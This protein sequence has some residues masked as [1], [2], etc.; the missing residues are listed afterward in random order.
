V[1]NPILFGKYHLIEKISAGG[2]AEVY[3]AKSYGVAGFE[4][5]LV[6]KKILPHLTSDEDFVRM[7]LDEARITVS[8]SHGNIVQVIELA[9]EGETYFM[10]MEY[11]HGYDL[12]RSLV[13]S[14]QSEP[15]P[16]PL[17]LYVLCEVL[18]ALDYA[19]RRKDREQRDLNIVHCD[20]SPQNVLLSFEG[21]VKL[22]DFGISRAAFQSASSQGVVRGKYAYMSPE[23]VEGRALDRRSDIFSVGIILWEMLTG[24]RLFKTDNVE[25]TLRKVL[26]APIPRPSELVPD[27][28]EELDRI[29]LKALSRNLK[30][31]YQEDQEM[32]EDLSAFMFAQ[33]MHVT[34]ADLAEYLRRIFAEELQRSR[35]DELGFGRQLRD[36]DGAGGSGRRSTLFIP[37]GS[38]RTIPSYQPPTDLAQAV[39]LSRIGA[40]VVC[41]EWN[42]R[43]GGGE[44]GTDRGKQLREV[45]DR[46]ERRVERLGGELWEVNH[47]S[48]VA[49]WRTGEDPA[50]AVGLAMN[51]ASGLHE[52]FRSAAGKDARAWV[53]DV[54]CHVGSVLVERR[55]GNPLF[56]WQITETFAIPRLLVNLGNGKGRVLVTR[57]ARTLAADHFSFKSVRLG[58]GAPPRLNRVQE[59]IP[60]EPA[61]GV[62]GVKYALY[63]RYLVRESMLATL[64]DRLRD[65]EEGKPSVVLLLGDEGMGKSRLREEYRQSCRKLG[66]AF[67]AGS[68]FEGTRHFAY[69]TMLDALRKICGI[70][71]PESPES[72]NA[73][74]ARLTQLGLSPE[75]LEVI[76]SLFE[77][78][79]PAVAGGQDSGRKYRL[80]MLFDRLF[81]GLSKDAPLVLAFEDF[82]HAD[83][84]TEEYI[85]HLVSRLNNLKLVLLL[86]VP[87]GF[88]RSWLASAPVST[89]SFEGMPLALIEDMTRDMLGVPKVS[90]ELLQT[91]SSFSSGVPRYVKDLVALMIEEGFIE[92]REDEACLAEPPPSTSLPDSP[93]AL[94]AR[95]FAALPEATRAILKAGA[96]LGMQ[97]PV[98]VVKRL[99]GLRVDVRTV[100]QRAVAKGILK[101][102]QASEASYFRFR[103]SY[104]RHLAARQPLGV[105]FAELHR[106]LAAHVREW[107]PLGRGNFLEQIAVSARLAQAKG[108][109]EHL[110]KAGDKLAYEQ[111]IGSALAYYRWAL[112]AV[113]DGDE[114]GDERRRRI[115][116]KI[117]GTMLQQGALTDSEDLLHQWLVSARRSGMEHQAVGLMS[118]LSQQYAA[119]GEMDRAVRVLREAHA[120]AKKHGPPLVLAMVEGELGTALMKRGDIEEAMHHLYGAYQRAKREADRPAILN[121]ALRVG[122][123]YHHIGHY[124]RALDSFR[125][126]VVAARDTNDARLLLDVLVALGDLHRDLKRDNL[127]LRCYKEALTIARERSDKAAQSRILGDIGRLCLDQDVPQRA[128]TYLKAALEL[129][130]QLHRPALITDQKLSL[131]YLKALVGEPRA[132]LKEIHLVMS[133]PETGH[134]RYVVARAHYLS[135]RCQLLMREN[136][137]AREAFERCLNVA[138][139]L[140]NAP[141]ARLATMALGSIPSARANMPADAPGNGPSDGGF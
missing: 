96:V 99:L 95:R 141:L 26:S 91:I 76:Q 125:K 55:S 51:C 56:G 97:F 27:V 71:P 62:D 110:E 137:R 85:S 46:F 19:H 18:K 79:E 32:L 94:M 119:R 57:Q 108:A 81:A 6:I 134:L 83:T 104:Y 111:G 61:A 86:E 20:V 115:R 101:E 41:A 120:I 44:S 13:R 80:F 58:K 130:T 124:A 8:L 29:T 123:F 118:D 88:S 70:T 106:R 37:V 113:R 122:T 43:S 78:P 5:I 74:L 30:G 59:L 33:G 39:P 121:H 135:G 12:A 60:A 105:P 140:K 84:L 16:R 11:V 53:L 68:S 7:F 23:Q 28:H 132:A 52:E 38:G 89:V 77:E 114:A 117:A 40:A 100:L 98:E 93:R 92:I 24:K 50:G 48:F 54:G 2:M 17:C 129:S 87:P 75:E 65:A 4:K 109:V 63:T 45:V 64:V 3:K 139:D 1:A 127:S 126:V 136:R 42:R 73:K 49:C 131:A 66:A 67:F 25:K 35:G 31:R 47:N 14:R 82:Q 128:Y 22:T 133:R 103:H 21:E 69:F 138:K 102:R 90:Y 9:K 36:G 34:S 112:E 72:E 10:A 15:F 107:A 116:W